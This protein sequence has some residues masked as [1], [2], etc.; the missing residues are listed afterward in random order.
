M[1]A[2]GSLCPFITALGRLTLAKTARR[3]L[4]PPCGAFF[5]PCAAFA[6]LYRLYTDASSKTSL[7]GGIIQILI[8]E[9]CTNVYYSFLARWNCS[10]RYCA[11]LGSQ[12]VE[13]TASGERTCSIDPQAPGKSRTIIV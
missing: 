6:C 3:R 5:W 4:S 7:C 2:C 9:H 8:A 1:T 12:R 13:G 10:D 11:F